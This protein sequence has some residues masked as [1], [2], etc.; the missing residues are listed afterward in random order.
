MKFDAEFPFDQTDP[1]GGG[2]SKSNNHHDQMHTEVPQDADAAAI[3]AVLAQASPTLNKSPVGV[4]PPQ[5]SPGLHPVAPGLFQ[6][7]VPIKKV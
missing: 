3:A 4:A 1:V 5:T 7:A 2:P 6:T